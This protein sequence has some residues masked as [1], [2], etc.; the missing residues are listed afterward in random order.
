MLS[1]KWA[2][3]HTESSLDAN[4]SNDMQGR[5]ILF[6]TIVFAIENTIFF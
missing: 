6:E 5:E 4:D 1:S 2:D 3:V